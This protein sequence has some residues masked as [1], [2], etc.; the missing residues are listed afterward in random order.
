MSDRENDD[1][2][3]ASG[4]SSQYGG[5]LRY[6]GPGTLPFNQRNKGPRKAVKSVKIAK[7][8]QVVEIEPL[9]SELLRVKSEIKGKLAERLPTNEEINDKST[10]AHRE[11]VSGRMETFDD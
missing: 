6:Q 1:E 8:V 2:M 7:E 4:V 9:A 10:K 3:R 5:L 11:D